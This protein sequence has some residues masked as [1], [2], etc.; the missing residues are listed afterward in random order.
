MTNPAVGPGSGT[1]PPGDVAAGLEPSGRETPGAKMAASLA[2]AVLRGTRTEQGCYLLAAVL[3]LSGLVHCGVLLVTGGSWVG[4]LSLRKPAT[5]GLSFGLTLATVTWVLSFVPLRSRARRL[6][7]TVFALACVAEV[8]VITV[9]AWRG[10]TSH[11]GVT[12]AGAGI[13]AASAAGGAVLIVATMAAATA[14]VYRPAASSPSTSA[15]MRLALRAGFAALMAAL[16][17]GVYMLARGLVISRGVAGVDA[18][19]A[20]SAGI[21]PGH[22][23]TMHGVLVLPALAW[24]TSFADRT[25]HFRVAI[26]RRACLGYLL[27]AGIAVVDVLIGIR[28]REPTVASAI[29]AGCAVTGTLLLAAAVVSAVRA[30]PPRTRV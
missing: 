15:S 26:V 28:P 20:F 7:L 2:D 29:G 18:A 25:E 6:L 16:A 5:F 4:P 14:A 3:V 8:V 9:Q 27:L 10:L 21:K 23:A 11:F 19:F 24:L 1:A 12:G 13:V 17:L 30:L 22:A